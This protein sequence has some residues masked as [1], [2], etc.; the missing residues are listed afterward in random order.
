MMKLGDLKK[1]FSSTAIHWRVGSTTGDKR[2][3][4]ALAYIDARDVMDRLDDVCGPENWQDRYPHTSGRVVCEIG[5]RIGNEWVWKSDGAGD[6]AVEKEKGGL[7]DAFKR[8]AVMWGIGRYLYSLSAPWVKL[9]EPRKKGG[10][11]YASGFTDA[12]I[13]QLVDVHE[14]FIGGVVNNSAPKISRRSKADSRD[15]FSSIQKW[16]NAAQDIPTL[17]QTWRENYPK[18]QTMHTDFEDNITQIKDDKKR[19]LEKVGT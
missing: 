15:D 9:K 13:R 14:K 7:S 8:A 12:S 17:A 1:P 10:K 16:I 18:V 4:M 6:T 2:E 11:L 3:G 5:I 19:E